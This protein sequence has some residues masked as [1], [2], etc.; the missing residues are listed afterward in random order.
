MGLSLATGICFADEFSLLP[1]A[2]HLV[3]VGKK[4]GS[5]TVKEA[6]FEFSDIFTAV[7]INQGALAVFA[8]RFSESCLVRVFVGNYVLDHPR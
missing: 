1:H 8:P 7:F 5:R 3:T 2:G 6:V 4:I